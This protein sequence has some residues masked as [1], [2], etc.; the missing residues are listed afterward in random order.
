MMVEHW[1]NYGGYCVFQ[2]KDDS[3]RPTIDKIEGMWDYCRVS[4]KDGNIVYTT[5]GLRKFL[6][7]N[8]YYKTGN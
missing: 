8:K 7:E 4:D 6:N 2:V 1:S 5:R 3:V